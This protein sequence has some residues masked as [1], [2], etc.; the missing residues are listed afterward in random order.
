[1]DAWIEIGACERHKSCESVASFMDA[2][3]EIVE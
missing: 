3:I 1:M 2:W